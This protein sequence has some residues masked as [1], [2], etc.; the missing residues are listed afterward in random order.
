M[1]TKENR[2]KKF[3]KFVVSFYYKFNS[4]NFINPEIKQE[5]KDRTEKESGTTMEN[6]VQKIIAII[7]DPSIPFEDNEVDFFSIHMNETLEVFEK[8][9]KVTNEEK[10]HL[11]HLIILAEQE[12]GVNLEAMQNEISE[13]KNK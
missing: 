8:N 12:T 4:D 6:I 13:D 2:S 10:L 11:K 5:I 7:K 3:H 1:E 9:E